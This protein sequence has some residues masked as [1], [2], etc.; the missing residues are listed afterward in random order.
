MIA[1]VLRRFIS[2]AETDS[3]AEERDVTAR[4]LQDR[5]VAEIDLMQLPLLVFEAFLEG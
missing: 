3:I 2:L 5:I 4:N 1:K